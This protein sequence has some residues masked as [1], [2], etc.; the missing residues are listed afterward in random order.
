MMAEHARSSRGVVHACQ[1]CDVVQKV[2][3]LL[4]DGQLE[5]AGDLFE[6]LLPS[7]EL[8]RLMGMAYAKEIM[9]RRGIFKNHRV[10][11][12]ARALDEYDMAEIDRTWE[13]IPC[14]FTWY[15]R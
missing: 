1:F 13:R 10:R 4:D 2:W 12:R 7:L 5:A 14:C 9:I 6:H 11:T 15:R 8:E 3:E